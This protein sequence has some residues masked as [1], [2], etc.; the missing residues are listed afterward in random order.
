MIGV[1]EPSE[2]LL[3][4]LL[5]LVSHDPMV[6]V[7]CQLLAVLCFV[8][9]FQPQVR[10]KHDGLPGPINEKFWA[11]CSIESVHSTFRVFLFHI[12]IFRVESM[13]EPELPVGGRHRGSDLGSGSGQR[14]KGARWQNIEC[15][16]DKEGAQRLAQSKDETE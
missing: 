7:E 6:A 14:A 9:L 15:K 11:L 12:L 16:P 4:Q 8:K 5:R 1:F 10:M 2:E 3:I 13:A